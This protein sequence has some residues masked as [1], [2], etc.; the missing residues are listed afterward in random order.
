VSGSEGKENVMAIRYNLSLEPKT[1]TAAI[2]PT[3]I[4]ALECIKP[5]RFD[6]IENTLTF[7]VRLQE[8][9]NYPPSGGKRRFLNE[10]GLRL[11]TDRVMEQ[12]LSIDRFWN[13]DRFDLIRRLKYLL[14]YNVRDLS[15]IMQAI[16]IGSADYNIAKYESARYKNAKYYFPWLREFLSDD[17]EG[18]RDRY[19]FGVPYDVMQATEPP[20][21]GRYRIALLHIHR[22]IRLLEVGLHSN[23][24]TSLLFKRG[25]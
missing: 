20:G 5:L 23:F 18:S 25:M 19:L 4:E 15:K 24:R 12:L 16:G 10:S 13:R 1:S 21:I 6:S 9:W 11:T 17:Q 8:M 7:A 2:R 14:A 3:F 22:A